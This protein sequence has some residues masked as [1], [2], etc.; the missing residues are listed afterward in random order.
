MEALHI[1]KPFVHFPSPHRCPA[2]N[3]RSPS[4]SNKKRSPAA[5]AA[6]ASATS[7]PVANC[8]HKILEIANSKLHFYF[9]VL[10]SYKI[11]GNQVMTVYKMGAVEGEG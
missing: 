7:E 8:T 3:T 4:C 2:T 6:K 5:S 10:F 1:V 9:L 11:N